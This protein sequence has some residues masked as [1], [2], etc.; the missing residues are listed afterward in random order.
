M[1]EIRVVRKGETSQ[2]TPQTSGVTRFAA[3]ASDT[4]GSRRLW[5]GHTIAPAGLVSGV[6][7][8]GD[9]ETAVYVLRGTGTFFSG[10]GLRQ[11]VD[12]SAGDFFLVPPECVH[13]EANFGSE[14]CEFIVA[15]STQDP[16]VVN[17]D[18]V[19]PPTDLIEEARAGG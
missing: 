19:E 5:L 2:E 4:V 8:H 17:L 6:H 15:R 10:E 12:A 11:R 13:V 7:H 3:I 1:D 18:D 16:I 9:S 14:E